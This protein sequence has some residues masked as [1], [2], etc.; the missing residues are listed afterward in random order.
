MSGGPGWKDR[1]QSCVVYDG[2]LPRRLSPLPL[3]HTVYRVTLSAHAGDSRPNN[4]KWPLLFVLHFGRQKMHSE[5]SLLG[6][7]GG[8]LGIS[9]QEEKGRKD[10]YFERQN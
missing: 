9:G 8:I 7:L 4:S 3:S 2:H 5:P 1:L 10:V 6:S